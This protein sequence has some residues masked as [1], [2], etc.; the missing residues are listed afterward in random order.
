MMERRKAMK[1]IKKMI[2]ISIIFGTGLLLPCVPCVQAECQEGVIHKL[3]R[4]V[5]EIPEA[6]LRSFKGPNCN[7]NISEYYPKVRYPD[8]RVIYGPEYRLNSQEVYEPLPTP[9]EYV[10]YKVVPPQKLETKKEDRANL[11]V[12]SSIPFSNR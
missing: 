10:T 7:D 5:F 3:V 11:H 4:T 8:L 12:Y 2:L 9:P 1:S 6:V